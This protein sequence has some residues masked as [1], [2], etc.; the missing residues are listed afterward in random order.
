[1]KYLLQ[2]TL[3]VTVASLG[4]LF[5]FAKTGFAKT[6]FA[7]VYH[8]TTDGQFTIRLSFVFILGISLL[9]VVG[10]TSYRTAG[11]IVNADSNDVIVFDPPSSTVLGSVALP[12]N[13]NPGVR[14]ATISRNGS[15]GFVAI[16][17]LIYLIDMKADPPTLL[18]G[19]TNNP[20]TLTIQP[21]MDL[22]AVPNRLFGLA[23][24][25]DF[26]SVFTTLHPWEVNTFDPGN[27]I[28]RSIDACDN[29]T[30]VLVGMSGLDNV[31]KKLFVDE[32]GILSD[33]GESVSTPKSITNVYCAPGSEVGVMVTGGMDADVQS[34][35]LSN[36]GAVDRLELTAASMLEDPDD[37]IST[38][39]PF[40]VS[41]QFSMDG[42]R[43]F[44]R[45]TGGSP[46]RGYVDRFVINPDTGAMRALEPI[47]L[48]EREETWSWM[49]GGDY[50][51]LVEEADE[52]LI[53][54]PEA[55][56]IL[57][58]SASTGQRRVELT[59]EYFDRPTTIV[60][61]EPPE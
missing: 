8:C 37:P 47:L 38:I 11:L 43:F 6:E 56:E 48:H 35:T 27:S 60:V 2:R 18:Q 31:V 29:G 13:I 54:D 12:T 22:V 57:I 15:V 49:V 19:T 61:V 26:I 42:T 50:L 55:N 30:T 51:A 21:I 40:G 34:F 17:N 39:M 25:D 14:P 9:L 59:S 3:S 4:I 1:M 45:S 7:K 46:R 16:G 33:S 41:G 44:A 24:G 36:M 20:I 10:C 23:A 58:F 52:I 28:I 32:N 53:P 5:G